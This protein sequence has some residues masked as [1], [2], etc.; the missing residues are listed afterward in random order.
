MLQ[1]VMRGWSGAR[2]E[3]QVA[4]LG[5]RDLVV[6]P[7][8]APELDGGL[9]QRK[10]VCPGR[11]AALSAETVETRQHGDDRVGGGLM[12][13]VVEVFAANM[14]LYTAPA[15]DLEARRAQKEYV[16]APDGVNTNR[17]IAAQL[18]QPSAGG[19]ID[20]DVWGVPRVP[21]T[22]Q[23]GSHADQGTP[24]KRPHHR[25]DPASSGARI[26]AATCGGQPRSVNSISV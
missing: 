6:V 4:G 23:R 5:E 3:L 26:L 15:S 13:D 18:V 2:Q 12:R 7:R 19:R 17:T 16:Q 20:P 8:A 10:L 1:C 24:G 21:G 11:E 9:Q 25:P 22:G 14:R